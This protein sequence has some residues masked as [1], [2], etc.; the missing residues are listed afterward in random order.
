MNIMEGFSVHIKIYMVPTHI[1]Q[2]D[3]YQSLRCGVARWMDLLLR[4][5]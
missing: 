3:A 4:Q 1:F 2:T 5:Y